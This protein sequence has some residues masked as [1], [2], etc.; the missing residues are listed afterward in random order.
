MDSSNLDLQNIADF[1]DTSPICDTFKHIKRVDELD[2][3]P[4]SKK[5]LKKLRKREHATKSANLSSSV[6]N[7]SPYIDDID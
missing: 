1:S 7:N 6:D 5:K 4:L 2:Y 3:L